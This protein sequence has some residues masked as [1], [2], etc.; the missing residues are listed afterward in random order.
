MK[1]NTIYSGFDCIENEVIV[2]DIKI[3]NFIIHFQ[4]P[5]TDEVLENVVFE[6]YYDYDD[7]D[8]EYTSSIITESYEEV[9]ELLEDLE[10]NTIGLSQ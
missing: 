2:Q 3:A 4:H 8:E 5:L 6:V 7:E 9:L 1:M 10:T